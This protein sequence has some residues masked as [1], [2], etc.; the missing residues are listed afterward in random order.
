VCANKKINTKE[1]VYRCFLS[2]EARKKA[3]PNLMGRKMGG[4]AA[5]NENH[6]RATEGFLRDPK[7]RL[8]KFKNLSHFIREN[9][10]LFSEED[11]TWR[12]SSR[13]FKC[14]ALGGLQ[15]IMP[16]KKNPMGSWK[17]WTIG[18]MVE[19]ICFSGENK[20]ALDRRCA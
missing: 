8:H 1:K 6:Y 4:R 3:A 9:S 14:R 20:D 16:T 15:S 11:V 7:G 13:Y 12:K 10:H 17:G 19:S 2:P 5:K 18:S